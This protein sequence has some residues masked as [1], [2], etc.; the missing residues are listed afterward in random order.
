MSQL[1]TDYYRVELVKKTWQKKDG[2]KGEDWCFTNRI[3]RSNGNIGGHSYSISFL[4][5]NN[6][7]KSQ[8]SND[9][10]IFAWFD[11]M[12]DEMAEAFIEEHGNVAWA[13]EPTND[14]VTNAHYVEL[15]PT[16]SKQESASV[17]SAG[18]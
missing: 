4:R 5:N 1:I 18:F 2:T 14:I 15:F 3:P 7:N 9:P 8:A 11:K 10:A 17:Q 16:E 6:A 12:T 13:H